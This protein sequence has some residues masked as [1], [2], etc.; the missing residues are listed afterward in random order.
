MSCRPCRS[1]CIF[2]L[3]SYSVHSRTWGREKHKLR[4]EK[5]HKERAEE[6]DVE[7]FNYNLNSPFW[8]TPKNRNIVIGTHH[9]LLRL[10]HRLLVLVMFL[11]LCRQGILKLVLLLMVSLLRLRLLPRLLPVNLSV[12]LFC[13]VFCCSTSSL[14]P[15]SALRYRC[16][17]ISGIRSCLTVNYSPGQ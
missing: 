5:E 12:L 3:I 13:C 9:P 10:L 7:E 17:G 1:L 6:E 11:P 16:E 15:S 8:N 4:T 14:S 2:L